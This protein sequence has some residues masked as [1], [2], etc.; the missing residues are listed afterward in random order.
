MKFFLKNRKAFT[1]A[2]LL[3]STIILAFLFVIVFSF[4]NRVNDSIDI[5]TTSGNQVYDVLNFQSEVSR[6]IDNGYTERSEQI[7]EK[8]GDSYI[9]IKKNTGDDDYLV[10]FSKAGVLGITYGDYK[11]DASLENIDT[12]NVAKM[13]Y[14]IARDIVFKSLNIEEQIQKKQITSISTNKVIYNIKFKLE[15]NNKEYNLYF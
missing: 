1:F 13:H 7:I 15:S 9:K 6:A 14:I 11:T 8:N 5:T 12:K 2:E 10:I 4:I 3:V